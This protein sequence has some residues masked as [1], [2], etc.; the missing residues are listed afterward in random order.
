MNRMMVSLDP[1]LTGQIGCIVFA[2]IG[3]LRI[4]FRAILLHGP[5]RVNAG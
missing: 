4:D 5:A 1:T 2:R 3:G